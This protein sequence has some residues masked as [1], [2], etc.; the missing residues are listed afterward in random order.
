MVGSEEQNFL[1]AEGRRKGRLGTAPRGELAA[2]GPTEDVSGL[3]GVL[4][5]DDG[6]NHP[7]GRDTRE[8]RDGTRQPAAASTSA[9]IYVTPG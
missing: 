6:A 2:G 7:A 3:R 9:T 8:R 1:I 5:T 4:E